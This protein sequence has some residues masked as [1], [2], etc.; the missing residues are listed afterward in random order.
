MGD[1]WALELNRD[2]QTSREQRIVEHRRQI[3]LMTSTWQG[4]DIFGAQGVGFIYVT[5]TAK[6]WFE[7]N[8]PGHL[9]FEEAATAPA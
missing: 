9:T 3:K 5:E 7:R 4:Q 2:A 8:L 1:L 6:S